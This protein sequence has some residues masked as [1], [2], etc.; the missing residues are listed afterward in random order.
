ML[1]PNYFALHDANPASL[2]HVFC[3]HTHLFTP[4]FEYPISLIAYAFI[5]ESHCPC[6]RNIYCFLCTSSVRQPSF[7]N[8]SGPG[9]P[10][11]FDSFRV[12]RGQAF[13]YAELVNGKRGFNI[14]SYLFNKG[15]LKPGVIVK[16]LSKTNK[17]VSKTD[18]FNKGVPKTDA[19]NKG[20]SKTDAF[21]K[22]VSKPD[23]LSKA[24]IKPDALNKGVLKP[25][26]P[27]KNSDWTK[28]VLNVGTG[29]LLALGIIG[30]ADLL[31]PGESSKA[32]ERETSSAST[33]HGQVRPGSTSGIGSAATTSPSTRST[34]SLYHTPPLG[35]GTGIT[36]TR[37]LVERSGQKRALG[38]NSQVDV[39]RV[40]RRFV[41][42]FRRM[43]N[44]LD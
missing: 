32:A 13:D 6:P 18:A 12:V 34:T 11:M 21:N 40:S 14:A 28:Y 41:E 27:K 16:G 15:V 43:L 35:S 38:D 19:S 1:M 5:Y 33:S 37:A 25:A 36:T 20:V 9:L 22:G 31:D 30:L 7:L 23:G 26:A 8:I 2:A 44:E 4:T 3:S 10:D 24:L 39:S 42:V 17:G 29:G